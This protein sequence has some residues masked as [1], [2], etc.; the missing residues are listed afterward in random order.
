MLCYQ[1]TLNQ[2]RG[3]GRERRGAVSLKDVLTFRYDELVS[4][5]HGVMA[6][7]FISKRP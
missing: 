1:E 4:A 7:C 6:G 5:S 2:V 3:D